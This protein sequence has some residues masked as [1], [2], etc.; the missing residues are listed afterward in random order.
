MDRDTRAVEGSGTRRMISEN[1]GHRNPPARRPQ[2]SSRGRGRTGKRGYDPARWP[3]DR[4]GS[5]RSHGPRLIPPRGGRGQED[6]GEAGAGRGLN[7]RG[8]D[9]RHP[10]AFHRRVL[11]DLGHVLEGLEHLVHDLAALVDVR[12]LAAA[13]EDVDQHLVL[14]LEELAGPLDL[15]LDVVVAG[16]G[17]DADLLDLDL[18][19][20]LLRGP[21]LLRV[22]EL[23]EVHDLADRRPLVGGDLDQVEA[24]LAGRLHGLARRHDAEHGAFGVDDPHG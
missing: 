11:L 22:L 3:V 16:L 21:L 4:P 9:R 15:D 14:V 12:Q 6:P 24:R 18:V 20:L 10:L 2:I 5:A 13:E 8:D 23:A 7:A 19:L 1:G 17:P